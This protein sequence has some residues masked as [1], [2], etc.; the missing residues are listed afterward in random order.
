[1]CFPAS[2][3]SIRLRCR[4]CRRKTPL[5]V[6]SSLS[7]S[8]SVSSHTQSASPH[9]RPRTLRHTHARAPR[10]PRTPTLNTKPYKTLNPNNIRTLHPAN[11]NF[12]SHRPPRTTSRLRSPPR[13]RSTR[14]RG[15][16]SL[17][18][19]PRARTRRCAAWRWTPASPCPRTTACRRAPKCASKTSARRC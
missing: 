18:P 17:C 1:M 13:S 9:F 19:C 6:D 8:P 2:F 11:P 7:L 15:S 14:P 3:T 10:G 16:A 12:P 4:R 5:S